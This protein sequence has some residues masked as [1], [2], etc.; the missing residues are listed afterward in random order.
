MHNKERENVGMREDDG[1][2]MMTWKREDAGGS[3]REYLV[4]FKR[5]TRVIADLS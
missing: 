4:L 1:D 5:V 3:T 2:W